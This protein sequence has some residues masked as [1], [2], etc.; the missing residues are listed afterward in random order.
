[1]DELNYIFSN[2]QPE[3]INMK[4]SQGQSV[5][6]KYYLDKKWYRG[7]I[8]KVCILFLLS[9]IFFIIIIFIIANFGWF[10]KK[11]NLK[12]ENNILKLYLPSN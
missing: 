7:T 10:Q 2:S 8:L 5:I 11:K 1:M 6:V 3:P 9:L 12:S 4:W